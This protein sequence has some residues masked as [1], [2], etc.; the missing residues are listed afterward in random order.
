MSKKAFD[1]IMNGAQQAL[2]FARNE[3]DASP[4]RIH[5]PADVDVKAIRTE[6]GLTQLE[7]CSR[8][9]F[10]LARVRDWEQGRSRPDGALRAY[11][12]V[13]RKQ[14]SAVKKALEAAPTKKSPHRRRELGS[15]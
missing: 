4:Y 5:V 1:R 7:F 2:A 9:G 6:L 14:P 13:I 12:M 11:L 8:F 3:A 10:G 15:V